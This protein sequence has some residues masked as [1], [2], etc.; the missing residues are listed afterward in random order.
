[1]LHKSIIQGERINYS[2][3]GVGT[4]KLYDIMSNMPKNAL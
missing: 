4:H 2:A 1:M 3:Y